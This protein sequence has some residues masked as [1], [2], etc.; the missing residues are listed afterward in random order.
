LVLRS[1]VWVRGIAPES[2]VERVVGTVPAP[3]W[4]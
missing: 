4:R 3:S 2:I 1:E